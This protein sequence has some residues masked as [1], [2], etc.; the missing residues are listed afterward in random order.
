MM[1]V[2]PH[3]LSVQR[4]FFPLSHTDDEVRSDRIILYLAMQ[5]IALDQICGPHCALSLSPSTQ[6]PGVCYNGT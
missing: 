6:N 1:D 4:F 5:L 3:L 2:I